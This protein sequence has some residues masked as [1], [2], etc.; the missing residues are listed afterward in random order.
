MTFLVIFE[1]G[2]LLCAVAN[3]SDMLIVG[4]VVA[5]IGA[6]GMFSGALAIIAVSVDILQRPSTCQPD[7]YIHF[8][9]ACL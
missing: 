6:A 2:S 9:V 8:I 7:E 3:S 5:G 1:V 4:R